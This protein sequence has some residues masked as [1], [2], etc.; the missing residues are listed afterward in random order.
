MTKDGCVHVPIVG[1]DAPAN[2]SVR[3]RPS[4]DKK[5]LDVV[6]TVSA[7]AERPPGRSHLLAA[8]MEG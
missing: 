3:S 5:C 7:P 2:P 8:T 4:A 6:A 1:L